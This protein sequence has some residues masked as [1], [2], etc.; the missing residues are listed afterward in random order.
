MQIYKAKTSRHFM[1]IRLS[2]LVQTNNL[3]SS[4]SAAL[5]MLAD[6][7]SSNLQLSPILNK[8]PINQNTEPTFFHS[9]TI[10]GCQALDDKNIF[11]G[12]SIS[13]GF[14]YYLPLSWSWSSFQVKKKTIRH[15]CLDRV[16]F[17]KICVITRTLIFLLFYSILLYRILVALTLA[18]RPGRSRI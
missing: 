17:A 10:T 5:N 12:F 15:T 6:K 13:W 16:L 14:R 8:L 4:A 1:L 11:L 18:S 9:L 7:F 3:G 2:S